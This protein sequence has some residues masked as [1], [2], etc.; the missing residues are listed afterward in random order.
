MRVCCMVFP[1]S[2]LVVL[3]DDS[4]TGL[5]V[6]V[7]GEGQGGVVGDGWRAE[8]AEIYSFV[9]DGADGGECDGEHEDWV[10]NC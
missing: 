8:L 5:V 10:S 9:G 1:V 6:L 7:R 4:T 2:R 3:E